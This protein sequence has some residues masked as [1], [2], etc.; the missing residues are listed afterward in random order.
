MN[1]IKVP[2]PNDPKSLTD[3]FTAYYEL[4]K[5]LREKCP[6]D[7]KQTNESIAPLILEEA[8]EMIEA[9]HKANDNEFAKELGDVL[10]HV[11]MHSVIAKER[12]AFGFI[13]VLEK[14]RKKLVH[15]HPHVFGNVT[16]KNE[17]EVLQNWE[18]LKMQEGQK[19]VLDGV[20]KAMPSLLR[21]ERIQHK[22]SR[23]GFDWKNRYDVWDKVFEELQEFREELNVGDMEKAKR[24][25]GDFLFAL[26]N[27][28]RKYE[29]V[30]E[31]ELIRTNDKFTQRFQFIERSAKESGKD[32]KNMS[33]EEMDELWNLAKS[34]GL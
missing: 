4:V 18:A 33:L 10:L 22:A 24:E 16:A 32:L 9:I 23:V 1:K 20:P 27:M 25:F 8:H 31:D 29:I 12:N 19:S 21:A 7:N 30:A 28:A 14:S 3:Q 26:V 2:E 5:I 6:W 11:V 17:E 15:R 13:D 34:K